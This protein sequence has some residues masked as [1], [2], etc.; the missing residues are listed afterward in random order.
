MSDTFNI[1]GP[2]II[3]VETET[4]AGLAEIRKQ[5][6]TIQQTMATAAQVN[7]AAQ[8]LRQAVVDEKVELGEKVQSLETQI[9]ALK[10]QIQT[11]DNPE[12]DQAVTTLTETAEEIKGFVTKP[13]PEI[14]A[15]S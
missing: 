9:A 6:N 4:P 8:D 13:V 5:L 2:I 12:L 10:E 11:G 15:I 14:P 7:K 1:F 3:V